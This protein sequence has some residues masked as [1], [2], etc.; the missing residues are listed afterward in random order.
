[1][2]TGALLRLGQLARLLARSDLIGVAT[3]MG[4]GDDAGMGAIIP[5]LEAQLGPVLTG[6]FA[7]HDELAQPQQHLALAVLA[8]GP[9]PA[10][11]GLLAG[12]VAAAGVAD[13]TGGAP[14]QALALFGRHG[15]QG[16]LLC[17]A[18]GVQG[19][20]DHGVPPM[21]AG[22]WSVPTCSSAASATQRS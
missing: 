22:G 9:G 6:L 2:L 19:D 12:D 21:V 8:T 7:D 13:L 15:Q 20:A 18:A 10:V 11:R 17:C 16:E 5:A 14:D 1:M 3:L 4:A